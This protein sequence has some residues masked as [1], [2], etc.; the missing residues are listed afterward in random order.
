MFSNCHRFCYLMTSNLVASN[1]PFTILFIF[2]FG[3]GIWVRFG[4]TILGLH[5]TLAE[6]S[7]WWS[8]AGGWLVRRVQNDF[9]ACYSGACRGAG[10]AP[11][12]LPFYITP[13]ARQSD[14]FPGRSGL[15][16]QMFPEMLHGS[17]QPLGSPPPFPS[18]G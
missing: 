11:L 18:A 2:L 10:W 15:R 3:S 1:N 6:V 16:E 8:S 14:F 12:G 9:R 17:P 7:G 4:W 13:L 5:V